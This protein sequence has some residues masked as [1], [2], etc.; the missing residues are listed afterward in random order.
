MTGQVGYR[1]D[2]APVCLV[3]FAASRG[4]AHATLEAMSGLLDHVGVEPKT[5]R[6]QQ[7]KVYLLIKAFQAEWMWTDVRDFAIALGLS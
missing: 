2:G 6:R 1:L 4:F 5:A 7:D 3:E